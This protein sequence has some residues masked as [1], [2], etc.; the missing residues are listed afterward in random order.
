MG[1]TGSGSECALD[2]ALPPGGEAVY[3]VM[4]YWPDRR[5]L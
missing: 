5:R 2:V 4:K 1:P 3:A